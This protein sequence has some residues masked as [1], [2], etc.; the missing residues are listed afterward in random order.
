MK[1]EVELYLID[2]DNDSYR[3]LAVQPEPNM[4][5]TIFDRYPEGGTPNLIHRKAWFDEFGELD[6]KSSVY[7]GQSDSDFKE[8][9]ESGFFG[10]I[11]LYQN[12][13]KDL[14]E[15]W[16]KFSKIRME[17]TQIRMELNKVERLIDRVDG[18]TEDFIDDDDFF[19]SL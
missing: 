3:I 14:L 12:H 11:P 6:S 2:Y 15:R 9:R 7:S 4:I 18:K 5:M 16:I 19:S 1:K 17:E 8:M 13:K 10:E